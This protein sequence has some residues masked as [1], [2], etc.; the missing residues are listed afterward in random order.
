M[1]NETRVAFDRAGKRLSTSLWGELIDGKGGTNNQLLARTDFVYDL[2][3]RHVQTLE[4]HFDPH[5]G[6]PIRDGVRVASHALDPRGRPIRLDDARGAVTTMRFDTAGRRIGIEL[7]DGSSEQLVLDAGGLVL[8]EVSTQARSDG[9]IA[10]VTVEQH[11]YDA[12][13]REEA[14]TL[15]EATTRA[16]FDSLDFTVG[17]TDPR[18]NRHGQTWA[19]NGR[20]VA[21]SY[22][23]TLDGTGASA[24]IDTVTV[25]REH[26]DS[27]RVIRE[28]D[29]LGN[30]TRTT[31]DARGRVIRVDYPDG[32]FATNRYDAIGNL[33]ET[34]DPNGTRTRME[35]DLL[36]RLVHVEV[37]PGFEVD[38]GT[39][40]ERMTHSGTSALVRSEDDDSVVIRRYDSL[41]Y[42]LA[43]SIDDRTVEYVR[44]DLGAIRRLRL[45][46][47]PRV[48]L[49]PRS[50]RSRASDRRRRGA[51]AAGVRG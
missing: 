28:T 44:D 9:G 34:R 40:E 18:D 48:G 46:L 2:H 35:Y 26:D 27:G 19:G 15:A 37:V 23:L 17:G 10:A 31:Y 24:V 42:L 38:P 29:P 16:S 49:R 22:A 11:E 36:D 39:T 13:G 51:R 32:T 30:S 45:S 25:T 3:G 21:E 50:A 14:T 41:G 33:V 4:A 43:E 8:A 7:D 6:E 12:L 1:G 47:G 20:L 5:T